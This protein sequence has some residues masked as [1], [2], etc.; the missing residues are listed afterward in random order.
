MSNRL[1]DVVT[2]V[3]VVLSANMSSSD[4][5]QPGVTQESFISEDPRCTA[6]LDKHKLDTN[7]QG[8]WP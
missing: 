7:I 3:K 5:S 1:I 6:A 4:F 8:V 2:L